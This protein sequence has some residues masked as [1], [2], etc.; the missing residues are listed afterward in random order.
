MLEL[1][2]VWQFVHWNVVEK[3]LPACPAAARVTAGP[4]RWPAS[5]ASKSL[6]L[7][8]MTR[9]RMLAW[10]SPQYWEHCPR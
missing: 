6:G 5:Q 1:L 8:A 3:R 10:L 9:N 4:W 7:W 2:V